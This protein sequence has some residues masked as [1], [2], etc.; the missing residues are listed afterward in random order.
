MKACYR[1][2][3]IGL[4]LWLLMSRYEHLPLYKKAMD[5]AVNIENVVKGFSRYHKYTLGTDLRN[6]SRESVHLIIRANSQTDKS[7]A[8]QLLRD[9]IEDLKVTIH[10]CKEVKAFKNFKTFQTLVEAVTDMSRQCEGWIKSVS[11]QKNIGGT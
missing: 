11:K 10:L 2:P 5:T 7:G 9:S 1:S 3:V 4:F 8:L 6:Q